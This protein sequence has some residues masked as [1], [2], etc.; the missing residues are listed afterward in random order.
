MAPT[1]QRVADARVDIGVDVDVPGTTERIAGQTKDDLQSHT[2]G[3]LAAIRDLAKSS[4]QA[5]RVLAWATGD[6]VQGVE[7]N[8]TRADPTAAAYV[9]KSTNLVARSF[10]NVSLVDIRYR[11]GEW[12]YRQY[13][14][15]NRTIDKPAYREGT[16][17]HGE[18]K[19][20]LTH[21]VFLPADA[22]ADH[23]AVVYD[24]VYGLRGD[25]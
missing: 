12:Q 2:E 11:E 8:G 17:T 13:H 1:E 20:D 7:P 6:P 4:V 24:V 14:E 3:A 22:W 16:T 19:T 15:L 10:S 25:V 5:A 18:I 23:L 21:P 9:L